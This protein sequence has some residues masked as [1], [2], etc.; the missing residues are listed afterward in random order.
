MKKINRRK[1]I[2]I[3]SVAVG[4]SLLPLNLLAR[5]KKASW[6][7]TA[8]GAKANISLYHWDKKHIENSLNECV[9]EI[10]RLEKIFSLFRRDSSLVQLNKNGFLNNPPKELLELLIYSNKISSVSNGSFD[11]TVQPLWNL[12]SKYYS[13]NKDFKSENFK[14]ELEKIKKSIGWEKVTINSNKIKFQEKNMSITLNGIAQGFI[15][16]KITELLEKKGFKNALINL[17]EIRGLGTHNNGN[18]WKIGF[19]QNENSKKLPKYIEL[20]N[21]AVSTSEAS[22]T[23]FNDEYHHLFNPK[24]GTSAN[25]AKSVTIVAPTATLAD[26]LSTTLA[27]M[28]KEKRNELLDKFKNVS[29][30]IV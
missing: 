11:V 15:T 23:K 24:S 10:R 21:Q 19:A 5:V 9:K 12:H 2:S 30:Y 16:D 28:P 6:E 29:S 14:E 7:G 20:K 22:G 18:S 8:L 17:G 26:A 3:S 27:V 4:L 25:F 13:K 1:F